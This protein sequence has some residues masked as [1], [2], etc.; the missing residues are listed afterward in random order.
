MLMCSS[1]HYDEKTK[2]L[3]GKR[4]KDTPGILGKIY[5]ANLTQDSSGPLFRYTDQELKFL[6]RTGISRSG[7]L[8]PYMLRPNLADEDISAIVTFLRSGDELVAPKPATIERTHYSPIGKFAISRTRPVAY[9]TEPLKKPTNP[10]SLGRYLVDNLAC[11]HCH[12][13]SFLSIQNQFPEQSRGYMGGGNKIKGADGKTMRTPNLTFDETGLAAWTMEDLAVLLR[14]G[15]TPDKRITR[16]P[17][18]LFPELTDQEIFSLYTYLKQLPHIE[19]E[20]H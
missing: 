9:S 3:S 13:K 6:I 16:Y 14:Q 15:I 1:C 7:K 5:A 12:S 18:P 20:L 10:V 4:M 2:S 19:N 8:M 11:Y 17:M